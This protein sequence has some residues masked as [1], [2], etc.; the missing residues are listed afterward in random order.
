MA[1][2]WP[3]SNIVNPPSFDDD[4]GDVGFF[5][6]VEQ[7]PVEQLIT[8]LP[9]ER[10]AVAILPGRCA[11]LLAEAEPFSHMAKM[12]ELHFI[13]GVTRQS[14]GRRPIMIDAEFD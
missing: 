13:F 12:T 9:G 8:H 4:V 5:Q 7:L 6:R 11:V 2:V 10:F 3:D 14:D 1:A